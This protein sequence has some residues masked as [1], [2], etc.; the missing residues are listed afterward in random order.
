MVEIELPIKEI[1]NKLTQTLILRK[2]GEK[3]ALE[4]G[5]TVQLVEPEGVKRMNP[6]SS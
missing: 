4:K 6:K 2:E 3:M 5:V 1:E